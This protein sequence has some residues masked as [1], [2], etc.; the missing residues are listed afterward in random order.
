MVHN[1]LILTSYM[2]KRCRRTTSQH[3]KNGSIRRST[4]MS[5]FTRGSSHGVREY[6][7]QAFCELCTNPPAFDAKK[8]GLTWNKWLWFTSLPGSNSIMFVTLPE[9]VHSSE[10]FTCSTF[11]WMKSASHL[12]GSSFL[13][14][15]LVCSA[16]YSAVG[17]LCWFVTKQAGWD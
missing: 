5:G 13:R 2:W 6:S 3:Q 15:Y 9:A 1:L 16:D 11:Y 14:N 12:P 10:K 8:T 4:W 17:G 7:S